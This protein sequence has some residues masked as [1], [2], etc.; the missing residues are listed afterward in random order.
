M[1]GVVIAL[2]LGAVAGALLPLQTAINSG[3]SSRLGAVLP[4][5]LISFAVGSAGLGLLVLV[6]GTAVPWAETAATQ[7]WWIWVG[8]AC[9]LVFRTMNIV[10]MPWIGAS[11]TVVLP[12]VGQVLG[13]LVIDMTGAFDA[14]V[15]PLD[16]SRVIGVVLVVLGAALVSQSGRRAV[17]EKA[18]PVKGPHVLLWVVVVLVGSL[19]SIQTAANG[20]LGQAMDSALAAALVS[21]LI[22]TAGLSVITLIVRP[23]LQRSGPIPLW[24]LGGGLAGAGFVLANA[25]N[26]PVLGVSLTVSIMVFG[27]V[28][29]GLVLD[30]WG[31]L[32]VQ[33]R[34]I[35]LRRLAGAE[36]V[37]LGVA[38]ERFA[39]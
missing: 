6:T 38:L 1:N 29:A 19:G 35:T 3:L 9:G 14:T 21:F 32:G 4:A 5:S 8:G 36:L 24:A 10:L 30:H 23:R 26:A 28:A 22:S 13:G 20:R 27:Q 16:P 11:A 15:L 2:L 33:T 7:P 39:G 34:P 37:L 25:V 12:I 18:L 31:L 17:L